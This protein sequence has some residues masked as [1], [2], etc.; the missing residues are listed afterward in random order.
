[1]KITKKIYVPPVIH[2]AEIEATALLAASPGATGGD[3]TD[4][5]GGGGNGDIEDDEE[6]IDPTNLFE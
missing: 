6:G 5:G 2:V 3:I 4:G 1:M